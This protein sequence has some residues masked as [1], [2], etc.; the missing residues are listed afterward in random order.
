[1]TDFAAT[2]ARFHLP[3]GLIYLDGNSLGP[4]PL[5]A[6]DRMAAVMTDEWGDLL[7]SGW[8]SGGADGAGEVGT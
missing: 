4:L 5:A 7:I 3:A 2:K 1:M 8:N 6:P